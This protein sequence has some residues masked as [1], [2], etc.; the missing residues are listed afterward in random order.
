[1][2][3]DNWEELSTSVKFGIVLIFVIYAQT[4]NS[5]KPEPPIVIGNVDKAVD[6]EVAI[7]DWKNPT[8]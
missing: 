5:A 7:N 2:I 1:M 4:P 8:S 3:T 6:A